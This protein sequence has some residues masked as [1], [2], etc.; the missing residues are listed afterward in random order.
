MLRGWKSSLMVPAG[1]VCTAGAAWAW[2][3]GSSVG[4]AG[5]G[6]RVVT[7]RVVRGAAVVATG[8]HPRIAGL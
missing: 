1:M 5:A 3:L 7:G 4:L 6:E 2:D 8:R